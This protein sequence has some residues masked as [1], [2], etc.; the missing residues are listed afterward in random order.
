MKDLHHSF[1]VRRKAEKIPVRHMTI[2]M[3]NR[4]N[5]TEDI[6]RRIDLLSHTIADMGALQ[7][8]VSIYEF[9][10][11]YYFKDLSRPVVSRAGYAGWG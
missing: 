7:E 4:K 10:Y 5:I 8:S 11:D 3:T 6:L 2:Y 9:G 1:L